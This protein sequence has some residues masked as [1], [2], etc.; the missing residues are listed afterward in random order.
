MAASNSDLQLLAQL[1]QRNE[2]AWRTLYRQHFG[3][4]RHLVTS[5]S[6]TAEQAND[7][8]QDALVVLYENACKPNFQLTASIKTYLYSVCRNLWLKQLRTAKKHANIADCEQFIEVT[9]PETATENERQLAVMEACMQ[10]LGEKCQKLLTMFYYAKA[11]METIAGEL[12][13]TNAANAKNQKYK[14]LMQLRK[15]ALEQAA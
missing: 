7:V 1:T 9:I 10:K 14:C 5:N 3:M 11:S 15:L 8:F 6:G 2:N 12:G 13:Y 4:V